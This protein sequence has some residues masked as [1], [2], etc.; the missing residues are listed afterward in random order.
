MKGNSKDRKVNNNVIELYEIV[1]NDF[2]I[3]DCYGHANEILFKEK[4][5]DKKPGF[6]IQKDLQKMR[7]TTLN[8][9]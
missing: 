8:S 4:F 1:L 5:F 9:R 6:S 7:I 2:K 3:E